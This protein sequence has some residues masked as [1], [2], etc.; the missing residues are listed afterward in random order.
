VSQRH[1]LVDR[2]LLSEP[3]ISIMYAR[4]PVSH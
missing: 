1:R 3:G 2:V 4:E